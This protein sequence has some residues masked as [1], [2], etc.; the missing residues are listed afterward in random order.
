[1]TKQERMRATHAS[2]ASVSHNQDGDHHSVEV[3]D[4][5]VLLAKTEHCWV[6][7]G[8]QIDY[9]AFGSTADQARDRFLSGLSE[10]MR[11]HLE[12]FSGLDRML[13]PV[14]GQVIRELLEE[15][16]NSEAQNCDVKVEL[17]ELEALA[18]ISDEMDLS[19]VDRWRVP[20]TA[21]FRELR[22]A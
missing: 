20:R 10:T 15:C 18:A 11:V 5:T 9:A 4:L 22:I 6:A 21:E 7:Q 14:P 16:E 3:G 13:R 19:M 12:R 8:F 1:M 17:V 2:G